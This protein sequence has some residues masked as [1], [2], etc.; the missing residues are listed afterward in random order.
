MSL[1]NYLPVL[2]FILLASC[3][4]LLLSSIGLNFLLGPLTIASYYGVVL[5]GL[6]LLMGFTGQVSMGQAGFFGIGSYVQAVLV[7]LDLRPWR[8]SGFI[9]LLDKLGLLL[10]RKDIYGQEVLN[11]SPWVALALALGITALI[12]FILGLPVLRLKGHYLAMATLGFGIIIHSLVYSVKLFGLS[13]GISGVPEFSLIPGL[14]ISS[15][16]TE[17]VSNFYLAIAVLIVVILLAINLVNSRIGR[18][19]RAL[20]G[21]E[22]AANSVG[23]NTSRYKLYTFVISALLAALGGALLVHFNGMIGPSSIDVM[24]SVRLVAL[25][26]A[27]GMDSIWG[28]VYMGFI[29]NFISLRQVFGSFDDI[30]F[31]TILIILMLFLPHGLI[32][33]SYFVK[34]IQPLKN[35]LK[36]IKKDLRARLRLKQGQD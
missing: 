33:A 19:L 1:K 9:G 16:L 11:L 32:R 5:I 4:Q 14:A 13:D 10:T 3:L 23:I 18:A 17:R 15:R 22:L 29:L 8:D 20:H 7:T 30:F 25:V 36:I 31:A 34:L 26:A 12:A 27:G 21:N 2:G 35:K 6:S 28:V 24:K